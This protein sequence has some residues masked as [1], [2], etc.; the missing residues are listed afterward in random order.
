M[1]DPNGWSEVAGPATDADI[2]RMRGEVEQCMADADVGPLL[3]RIHLVERAAEDLV[4]A[5][6]GDQRTPKQEVAA[7]K[8][9]W[10]LR[11]VQEGESND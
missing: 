9:F 11:E 3:K 1:T 10:V 6:L 4:R 5:V 8:M 2:E 7:D